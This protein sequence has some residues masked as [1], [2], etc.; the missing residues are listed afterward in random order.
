MTFIFKVTAVRLECIKSLKKLYPLENLQYVLS[1]IKSSGLRYFTER[2][3]ARLVDM[4][5]GD[6]DYSVRIEAV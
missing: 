2:C 4:A 6:K 1:F 5:L 3:S